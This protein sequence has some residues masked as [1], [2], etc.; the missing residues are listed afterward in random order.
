[1]NAGLLALHQPQR[2]HIHNKS[3]ARHSCPVGVRP[4]F[5]MVAAAADG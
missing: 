5:R 4:N 3:A 1:V 2:I